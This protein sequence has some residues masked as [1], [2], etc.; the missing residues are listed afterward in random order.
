[1]ATAVALLLHVPPAVA[2]ISVVVAV[3][4]MEFVPPMAAGTG[5]T[6]STVVDLQ[7]VPSL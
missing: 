5:F 1:M 3:P 4:Q 2:S 6:V 7:P